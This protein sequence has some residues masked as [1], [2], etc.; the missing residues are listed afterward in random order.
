M[1]PLGLSREDCERA[2]EQYRRDVDGW[3]ARLASGAP[4]ASGD[5]SRLDD[6]LFRLE[7]DVRAR[8]PSEA[9]VRMSDAEASL[10]A[11]VLEDWWRR[12]EAAARRARP[13]SLGS[14]RGRAGL[15]PA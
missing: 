4:L 8:A 11:P 9:R 7:V 10:L 2:L 13:W 12:L 3:L 15:P 14:E 5:Q 1:T 6:L